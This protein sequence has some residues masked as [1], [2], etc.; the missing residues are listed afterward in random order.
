MSINKTGH[1]TSMTSNDQKWE[2]IHSSNDYYLIKHVETHKLLENNL[3]GTVY[4]MAFNNLTNQMWHLIDKKIFRNKATNHVIDADKSYIFSQSGYG[5]TSQN[6]IIHYDSSSTT[7]S[8]LSSTMLTSTST[9]SYL[10]TSSQSLST[11]STYA[12]SSNLI[13]LIIF[14]ILNYFFLMFN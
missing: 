13:C 8:P 9:I 14:E 2:L 11:N 7:N 10:T 5:S 6:W 1:V 3:E 4:L 12:T